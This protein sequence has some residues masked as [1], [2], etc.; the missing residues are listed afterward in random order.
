M[1][2][3]LQNFSGCLT[4]ECLTTCIVAFVLGFVILGYNGAPFF[5]WALLALGA[6]V[7]FG[8]PIWL[9]GLI[10]V[11]GVIG[12]VKPI[13]TVL[14]SKG[15]MAL[16][17]KLKFLPTISETERTA[18]EAGSTWMEAELFSG[19]PRFAKMM[20]QPYP[21]LTTCLLYTS[22]AADERTSVDLGGPRIIKKKQK[23][24]QRKRKT[25]T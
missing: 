15:V 8:A 2:E 23:K 14:V 11:V 17:T 10:V 19:K 1:L 22:D 21:K 3:H 9:V 4:G 25:R 12:A 6:A 13:R 20:S 16:L 24:I 18:I 5:L 7:G